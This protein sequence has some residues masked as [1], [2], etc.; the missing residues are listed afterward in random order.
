MDLRS[1]RKIGEGEEIGSEEGRGR[2]A[3]EKEESLS[4]E[5]SFVGPGIELFQQEAEVEGA[6]ELH[7]EPVP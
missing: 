4:S 2:E 3:G 1:K 6:Q 7:K 5:E